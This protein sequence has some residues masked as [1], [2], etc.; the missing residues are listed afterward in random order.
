MKDAPGFVELKRTIHKTI[1][2]S[3]ENKVDR[4]ILKNIDMEGNDV[5]ELLKQLDWSLR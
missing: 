5:P 1:D 4:R 3:L 2:K